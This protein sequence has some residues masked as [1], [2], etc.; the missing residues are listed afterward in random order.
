MPGRGAAQTARHRGRSPRQMRCL[1]VADGCLKL[2]NCPG[3]SPRLLSCALGWLRGGR[4]GGGGQAGRQ[5]WPGKC[6]AATARLS[7]FE[8]RQPARHGEVCA[9]GGWCLGE[10]L[11]RGIKQTGCWP[12]SSFPGGGR[13]Q[14]LE[15]GRSIRDA[16]KGCSP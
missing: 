4:A 13:A 14:G 5:A 12:R 16:N 8:M 3:A 1:D 7:C 2:S 11:I 9:Q 6:P 15:G 10:S